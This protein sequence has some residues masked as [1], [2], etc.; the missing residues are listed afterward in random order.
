MLIELVL[1]DILNYVDNSTKTS[2][3]AHGANCFGV[4]GSGVAQVLNQHTN[5][6][7]LTVDRS[8]EL[9][10]INKLG[11]FSVLDRGPELPLLFNCYTQFTFGGPDGVVNV[12]WESVKQSLIEVIESIPEENLIDGDAVLTIPPIGCGLAGGT[13]ADFVTILGRLAL[14]YEMDDGILIRVT[15]NDISQ[16]NAIEA[17]MKRSPVCRKYIES[18]TSTTTY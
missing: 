7:I 18:R 6:D 10:D 17:A 8:T 11:S 15:T 13:V 14:E 4:M 9:A 12:H 2:A 16:H 3:V 5:G 1:D